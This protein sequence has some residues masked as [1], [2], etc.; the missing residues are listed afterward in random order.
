MG[1]IIVPTSNHCRDLHELEHIE[2]LKEY[3]A[4]NSLAFIVTTT[5]LF[6]MQDSRK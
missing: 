4:Y 2:Y 6:R 5:Q 3:L 1:R